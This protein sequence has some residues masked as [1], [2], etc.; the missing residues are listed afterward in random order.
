MRGDV[1]NV[2]WGCVEEMHGGFENFGGV[3]YD[4]GAR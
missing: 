2:V 1:E 3:G 4:W